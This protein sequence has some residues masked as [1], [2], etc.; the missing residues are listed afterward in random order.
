MV[1]EITKDLYIKVKN[2]W[3]KLSALIIVLLGVIV[4]FFFSIGFDER[5]MNIYFWSILGII[6]FSVVGHWLFYRKLKYPKKDTIGIV[7]A[8]K[9][10]NYSQY[11]KVKNDMID[12]LRSGLDTDIYTLIDLPYNVSKNIVDKKSMSYFLNKTK[13]HLLIIGTVREGK[14]KNKEK[15]EIEINTMIKHAPINSATQKKFI[16]ELN[17]LPHVIYLDKEDELAQFK[18]TSNYLVYFS[19]YFIGLA[20]MVSYN[21]TL[22]EKIFM[23]LKE[24][25]PHGKTPLAKISRNIGRYLYDIYFNLTSIEYNL[26]RANRQIESLDKAY[27]YAKKFNDLRPNSYPFFLF[28]ANYIFLRFRDVNNSKRAL[29]RLMK[30]TDAAHLYSLAFLHSYEGDLQLAIMFYKR[31][32]KSPQ[33]TVMSIEVEEYIDYILELEP[34][35]YHLY[36]SLSLINIHKEDYQLAKLDLQ[37]FLKFASDEDILNYSKTIKQIIDKVELEVDILEVAS[38]KQKKKIK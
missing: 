24:Q 7:I 2:D 31:A 3:T 23:E 37:N 35:K 20:A 18:F 30:Y 8:I 28:K 4:S 17:E 36:L 29:N 15:Y 38:S 34:D 33:E 16:N 11:E 12:R 10:Q 13:S 27:E 22:A 5:K 25:I 19:K 14:N 1:N 6:I 32:F 26:F 21:F 9:T